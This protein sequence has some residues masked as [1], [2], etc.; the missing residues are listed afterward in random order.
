MLRSIVRLSLVS[1][2]FLG[3]LLP[4]ASLAQEK[5]DIRHQIADTYGLASWSKVDQIRYTFNFESG[6]RKA[7]RTWT[8][9]IK[10][11]KVTYEGPD[12][13]GKP[14]KVTYARVNMPPDV[15][16]DVDPNFIN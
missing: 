10:T 11:D 16:K 12:G 6:P 5:P 7:A 3:L 1:S 14:A 8:W 4:A 13:A 9:E 15:V 2:L